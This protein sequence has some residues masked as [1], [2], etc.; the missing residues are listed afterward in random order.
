MLTRSAPGCGRKSRLRR[1][2]LV[3]LLLAVTALPSL[4]RTAPAEAQV[5]AEVGFEGRGWGHGRGLGQYG[6]LGYAL[7]QDRT[8][9]WILDHF[10]GGTTKGTQADAPISVRLSEHDGK[11]MIV[12]SGA[13]FTVGGEAGIQRPPGSA[14]RVRRTA[15]GTWAIDAG[16]GT[17]EAGDPCAG[18]WEEALAGIDATQRPEAKLVVPYAGDDV[19]LMIQVCGANLRHYRGSVMALAIDG[20]TRVVNHVAMEQYLRGVVPR[21]SPASWGD[22]GGG[23]GMEQLKSQAVAA[24]SY[25]WGENRHALFKTCDTTAC[26]VYGGAGLNGVR[27][28][29]ANTDQ[30]LAATGGEVRLHTSGTN[31]GKVARTEFS[32]S[33]GG[34]TAGGTFPAVVDEGDGYLVNGKPLNPNHTW[35][36]TV[37]VAKIEEAFPTIGDFQSIRVLKRNGLGADG[38]RVVEVAVNGSTA[39]VTV[40]GLAF[41]SALQLKSDWFT[42]VTPTYDPVPTSR[43]TSLFACPPPDVPDSGFVDIAEN[44]FEDEIECLRWYLIAAGGPGGRPADQYAPTLAVSRAQMATFVVRML[45]HIDGALLEPYD[46]TNRFTDVPD[47]SPHV[48]SINRLAGAGIVSGGAGGGPATSFSPDVDVSRAQMASFMARSLKAVTG[49]AVCAVAQDFFADDGGDVH[50]NCINGLAALAIVGG[51]GPQQYSP[52]LPVTRAQLSAFVMRTVDL[53]VE[54]GKTSP[55]A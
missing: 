6:S 13:A 29:H 38:G 12:T 31:A 21:E 34:H 20:V 39:S 42:V 5:G 17:T 22:L 55:P 48:E 14:A 32:S 11:D 44:T 43:D 36:T 19:G 16:P 35:S 23:K 46:G 7:G 51:T 45:D 50:E 52:G 15:D 30:A 26:Q 49:N 3:A 28:E 53:L 8:Y 10:Y 40:S 33:T 1:T 24:R 18:P 27:I 2:A 47:D 54:A 9:D 25:A 41:R 4:A 37:A